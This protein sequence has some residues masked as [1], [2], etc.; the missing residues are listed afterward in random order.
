MSKRYLQ[1][2]PIR[3]IVPIDGAHVTRRTRMTDMQTRARSPRDL[4][5]ASPLPSTSRSRSAPDVVGRGRGNLRRRRDRAASP[6]PSTPRRADHATRAG[7]RRPDAVTP[8][9]TSSVHVLLAIPLRF[10]LLMCHRHVGICDAG[11]SFNQIDSSF[12]I[13]YADMRPILGNRPLRDRGVGHERT[14][15]IGNRRH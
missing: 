14:Q 8:H 3:W 12:W 2:P 4:D 15:A 10:R 11:L 6:G 9:E 5:G 7:T 1:R 13:F